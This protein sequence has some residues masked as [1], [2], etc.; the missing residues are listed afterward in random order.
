LYCSENSIKQIDLLKI[1]V[2]GAE[3]NVLKGSE[4][5][6]KEKKIKICVFEFGQTIFDMGH[7]IEDFK[8]FFKKHDYKIHNVSVGQNIFAIDNNSKL[9]CFSVLT[10]IPN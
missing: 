6:F 7:T 5:M 8:T 3:L 2:E 1:D 10:A 4:K 9:A